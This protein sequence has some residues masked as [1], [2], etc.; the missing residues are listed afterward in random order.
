M[1]P[2]EKTYCNPTPLP[3]YPIGRLC[4]KDDFERREDFR[5]SA[6]PSVIYDNGVWY[7]YPSCGM[8][9]W[10]DDFIHWHHEK[11]EPYDVGYAPT[12]VKFRG[13]YLLCACKSGLYVSDSPLG[14]FELM[15]SF[16]TVDGEE[17]S[18]GDPMLFAD[19]DGRLYLYSGCG[20]EIR[21]AELDGDDPTR[22]ITEN[23]L[24]FSMDVENHPWERIGDWNEDPNYSWTEGAWMYKRG[25]T[26][27]L[28]YSA[29][30]THS[31]SYAMGAYKG[32]TPFGP[33]EYM[34]T[35]PFLLSPHGLVRGTGHGSLVDGPDGT[36]WVFYTCLLFY[37]HAYERRI[38]YDLITFDENGDIIPRAAS[39]NPVWA[40]GVIKDPTYKTNATDLI[41]TTQRKFITYASS[42]APG[43]CEIYATDDNPYTWWQPD[44]VDENPTL[45]VHVSQFGEMD[46]NAVRVWWRDVGF[47]I[48]KGIFPGPIGYKVEA[49]AGEGEWFCILDKS[50]NDV[51]MNIDY[52]PIPAVKASCVRL[53]ITKKPE[54]IEPGVINFTA[55]SKVPY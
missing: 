22:L 52:T 33:W 40:P 26:Y 6:D 14:P 9:Y 54:G 7:L 19:D 39:E 31:A 43:R 16:K 47:N 10:S 53:I 13:R 51:D 1:L 25:N 42:T 35:S 41:P 38:G 12:V 49:K 44:P 32:K 29:P 21:A 28:T 24:M 27:Y 4:Y 45:T 50:D 15:G 23:M 48:K 30:A 36:V 34:S 20:A 8:V 11:M 17:I 46:I 5:E 55:F 3:D 18:F 2:Y 37:A